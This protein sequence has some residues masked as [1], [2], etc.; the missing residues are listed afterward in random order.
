MKT[1]TVKNK[2]IAPFIIFSTSAWIKS[3][4]DEIAPAIAGGVIEFFIM[5]SVT[6]TNGIFIRLSYESSMIRKVLFGMPNFSLKFVMYAKPIA[7][8]DAMIISPIIIS[9]LGSKLR[10]LPKKII[11]PIQENIVEI[12]EIFKLSAALI[13]RTY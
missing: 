9:F 10:I 13:P 3:Y 1:S 11:N 4:R 2:F 8:F 5:F 12:D 6:T 7:S